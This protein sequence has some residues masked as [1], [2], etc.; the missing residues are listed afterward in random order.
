MIIKKEWSEYPDV[1]ETKY[2]YIYVD[3]I[4]AICIFVSSC[5]VKDG[6]TLFEQLSHCERMPSDDTVLSVLEVHSEEYIGYTYKHS[7]T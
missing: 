5:E 4:I 6:G 7:K 2:V 1:K 3:M